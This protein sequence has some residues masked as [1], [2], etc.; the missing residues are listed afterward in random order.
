[1]ISELRKNI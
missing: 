1:M